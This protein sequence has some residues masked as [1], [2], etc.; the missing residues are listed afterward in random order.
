[1][2]DEA[3]DFK[4]KKPEVPDAQRFNGLPAFNFEGICRK[5]GVK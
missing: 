4:I 1:V 5:I 3:P 2:I